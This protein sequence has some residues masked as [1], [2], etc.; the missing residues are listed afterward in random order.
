LELGIERLSTVVAVSVLAIV[1]ARASS[2]R[3]PGKVLAPVGG[4]PMLALVLRRVMLARR[5]DDVL[6]ATSDETADDPVSAVATRLGVGCYRGPRDDVLARF[7]EAIADHDGTVVRVTGDCPFV[8]PLVL[9]RLIASYEASG[10]TVYGS[11][12]D[13]PTFPDGLDCEVFDATA[14]RRA[15]AHATEPYD[16]EHVT[17]FLRRH[18]RCF[19][20]LTLKAEQDLSRLRWTVDTIEDLEFV[21]AVAARLGPDLV[22]A[23]SEQILE[24]IRRPP[25]LADFRGVRG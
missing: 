2:T 7:A 21:R 13:P 17:S 4:E 19:P 6:L 24:A 3:L 5:V 15:H 20:A 16:R 1:Q 10:H 9:D 22:A 11:N 12:I 25:T 23:G 8:D 18:P 14:L